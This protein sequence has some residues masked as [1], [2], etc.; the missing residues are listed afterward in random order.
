M[1]WVKEQKHERTDYIWGAASNLVWCEKRVED[2]P[3]KLMA[4]DQRKLVFQGRRFRLYFTSIWHLVKVFLHAGTLWS[5]LWFERFHTILAVRWVILFTD[6]YSKLLPLYFL[7]LLFSLDICVVHVGLCVIVNSTLGVSCQDHQRS[8]SV[9]FF[10]FIM[11][12]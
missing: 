9:L 1:A 3:V 6:S 11:S 12:F 10:I 8:L 2:E 5:K 7:L 4:P